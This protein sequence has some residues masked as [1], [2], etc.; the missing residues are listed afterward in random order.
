[1]NNISSVNYNTL[2]NFRSTSTPKQP[3]KTLAQKIEA[4]NEKVLTYPPAVIGLMNAVCWTSV[5]LAFDKMCSK[6]FKTN[7]ST[8]V[9][10]AVNGIVGAAMGLYA[11][12]QANKLQKAA[13][14]EGTK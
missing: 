3:Q 6:L 8:K 10:L 13:K 5:G 11:Y 1:M 4:N 7:S 2:A 14:A 12:N 9:S